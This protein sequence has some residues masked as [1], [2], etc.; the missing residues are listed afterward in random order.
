MWTQRGFIVKLDKKKVGQIKQ[1][2]K[3]S[4]YFTKTQPHGVRIALHVSSSELQ[5]VSANTY[6]QQLQPQ[7]IPF[8]TQVVES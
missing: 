3:M 1:V 2:Q 8:H 4:E 7:I 6:D 5:F